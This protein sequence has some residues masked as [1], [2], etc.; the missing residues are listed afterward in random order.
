MNEEIFKIIGRSVDEIN[1]D[2]PGDAKISKDPEAILFGKG[3]SLDS[4]GLVN[5]IVAIEQEIEDEL[6]VTISIANEKAMSR[7]SS[8]FKTLGALAEYIEFLIE[9]EKNG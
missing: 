2:L 6:D 1:E 5:L 7:K 8:P 3:S 9:E 4:M